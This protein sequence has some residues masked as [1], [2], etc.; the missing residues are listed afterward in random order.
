MGSLDVAGRH[1]VQDGVAENVVLRLPCGHILGV[2]SQHHRQ[3][4]LVV[5]LF[6]KVGVGL[7]GPAVRHGACDPLGEVD[8]VLMLGRKGIG[9]IFFRLIRVGHVVDTEADDVL[10]WGRDGAFR[11]DG[12]NGQ[13]RDARNGQRQ[14]RPH[15]RR[16]KGDGVGQGLIAQPQPAQRPDLPPVLR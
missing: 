9:G 5:Q 4:T 1:I 16:Q 11:R 6:H 2:L 10:R 7:D 13:G 12:L 14:S 15:L 3:L 8:G